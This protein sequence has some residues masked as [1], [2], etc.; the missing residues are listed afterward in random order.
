MI[1]IREIT[2]LAVRSLFRNKSRSI[3]TM[4]G[5][6]IG[7]SAVI[8]LVSIGQGLQS[9]ITQQFESLGSNLVMVL[10]GKVGGGG[11]GIS[12]APN[13]AGSKLTLSDVDKLSRLGGA[14]ESAGAGIEMPSTVSYLGKSK[15]TTTAGLTAEYQK[16]RNLTT[17]EGRMISDSDNRAGRNV[18][19]IG[20]GLVDALF[21]GASPIGKQV[22]MGGQKFQVVG[23]LSKIGSGGLGV[24]VN[25]FVVLPLT[26]AQKLFGMKSVQ[27]I[28]VKAKDKDSIPAAITQVKKELGKRL[29]EDDFSVV[30]SSSLVATIN[31]ILGVV[32]VALG[33]I[34]AI[35][36]IV[37]GVGIMNIMLVSVT[38]RT[39]EIG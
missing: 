33:G 24:D 4:L 2:K 22:T 35:S 16:M 15:Y 34:A 8:L 3:L 6:I 7:V 18:V 38:E 21:G 23:I 9:Y 10:P 11:G 14:V 5:I 27:A 17:S 12:G 36:L 32:T 31:Q 28:G 26:T 29:K 19:D 13:L 30:D 1:P 25:S 37:G 39:R 20:P